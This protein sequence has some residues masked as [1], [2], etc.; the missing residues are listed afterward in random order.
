MAIYLYLAIAPRMTYH[1]VLKI[2]PGTAPQ[3]L[4][5]KQGRLNIT[6]RETGFV[7]PEQIICRLLRLLVQI[8]NSS[9]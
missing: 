1:A 6:L 2:Y 8:T 7:A 9:L 5:V 3:A 4:G